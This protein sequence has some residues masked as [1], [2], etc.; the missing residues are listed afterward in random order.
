MGKIVFL[1]VFC[2]LTMSSSWAQ[3]KDIEFM[4]GPNMGTLRSNLT[5]P[6]FETKANYYSIIDYSA[7]V[8]S[9]YYFNEK[10]SLGAQLLYQSTTVRGNFPFEDGNGTGNLELTTSFDHISL[11][12]R[13]RYTVGHKVKF[14]GELGGFINCLLNSTP[15]DYFTYNSMTSTFAE[16]SGQYTRFDAG[17][18]LGFSSQ[19]SLHEKLSVKLSLS[20]NYGLV[21]ISGLQFSQFPIHSSH[22]LKSNTLNLLAGIVYS[23]H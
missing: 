11:P 13:A 19:I 12:I 3:I 15:K 9:S 21:N 10:F 23:L 18:S 2:L 20:D 7:G 1:H 17:L 8:G 16:A 5:D 4:L 22:Y 14:S 6:V